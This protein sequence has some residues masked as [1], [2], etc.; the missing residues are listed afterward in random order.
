MKEID[1]RGL[2]CPQPVV[3]VNMEIKRG[4]EDFDVILDSQASL[5]NVARILKK[6]KLNFDLEEIGDKTVYHVKR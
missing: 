1:T 4:K 2:S 5:E 6:F 3:M